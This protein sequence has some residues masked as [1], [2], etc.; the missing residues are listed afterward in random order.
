[1]QQNTIGLGFFRIITCMLVIKN[2]C[3]YLPTANELFG[4]NGI[5]PYSAYLELLER[6]QLSFLAY[7]FNY[8]FAPQI[9]LF[10]T[11]LSA[12][13]Y[14]LGY[15]GRFSG[16]L[17]VILLSVLKFRNGFI[18]DGSDN[19]MQVTLP[20]LV[21]ADDH[22]FF[23]FKERIV[24]E[25]NKSE[26][27]QYIWETVKKVAL[28]GLM[29]Q[30]CFVYFFTSF[31]KLQGDVWLNGTAIYYTMRVSDFMATS[32]NIPLTQ[33]HYFVVLGTYFTI[34]FEI[35]FPFLIWFNRTKYWIIFFGIM[36]H[37]GIWVFM[38]IDNFSWIMIGTYFVFITDTEYL[39]FRAWFKEG[40]FRIG[41]LFTNL[42]TKR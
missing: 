11:I 1:M 36:L 5:F 35:A 33:N 21:L 2:M 38:R 23:R 27:I 3:F 18:L 24:K 31:A 20:F 8:P 14:V 34:I 41:K 10:I 9:F 28:L 17:L 40:N 37:V 25:A 7:P 15:G 12:S 29:I 32:W 13:F 16:I 22:L 39:S 42:M 4:S 19:V 6:Y 26:I 30:V